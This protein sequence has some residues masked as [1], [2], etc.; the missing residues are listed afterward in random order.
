MATTIVSRTQSGAE[1]AAG[2][3]TWTF[4]CWFKK[5]KIN[6]GSNQ[7]LFGSDSNGARTNNYNI[8]DFNSNDNLDV[9]GYQSGATFRKITNRKFRDCNA[10]YHLVVAFDSTQSTADDR[11]KIYINGVRETSFSTSTNPAQDHQSKFFAQNKVHAFGR[12]SGQGF[13]GIISHCHATEGTAYAPTVFGSTDATTGEWKINPSPSVSYGT[14]GFFLFKNDNSVTNQAGNSSGNFA[15]TAG[16]LTKSED[17]PSNVFCTYNPLQQTNGSAGFENGNTYFTNGTQ[18]LGVNGTIA[19]TSGKYYAEFKVTG[20]TGWG[21]G[22]AD[23]DSDANSTV[24]LST[25]NNGYQSKY[26]GG[27]QIFLNGSTIIAQENNSTVVNNAG[28]GNTSFVNN[29]IVMVALDLD[30]N[31]LFFGK[32]GTWL[33]GATESEIEAGTST[34]ATFS[35][36][37]FNNKFWTW[38]VTTEL[39]NMR[40]NAG[41]GFFSTTAVTSA[42]TNASNNGIFEYDVPDGFTALSTKGLNL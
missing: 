9:N 16:T 36:T 19:A 20:N 27:K 8:I 12:G 14:N 29:D 1:S 7:E 39:E 4:S 13:D 38:S 10:W 42:G 31:N 26:T 23:V 6:G 24:N 18:W 3:R 34:N 5:N 15:V 30:N 37:S 41:N 35:G 28:M 2:R 33:R 22:V 11:I 25:S 17:C 21:V 40:M 32:N